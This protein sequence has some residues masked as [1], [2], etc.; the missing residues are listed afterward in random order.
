MKHRRDTN[1]DYIWSGKAQVVL[2]AFLVLTALLLAGCS[3][4]PAD[5][6]LD[7]GPV[8]RDVDTTPE[9]GAISGVV[10]SE[11]ITPVPGA[12]VTIAGSGLEATTDA[13]GTFV[14]EAL[15]PTLY[16]LDVRA[17]GYLPIQ[18]TA[19]VKVGEVAKPK[20]VLPADLA[21][22]PYTETYTHSG[23][24]QFNGAA[25]GTIVNIVLDE[26]GDNPLCDCTLEFAT[27]PGLET[28]VVEA[29]WEDSVTYPTGPVD[30][31][32]EVY[33]AELDDGTSDIQGGFLTSPILEHYPIE[34][35]GEDE[36]NNDWTVRLSGSG[37][38]VQVDQSYEL[39]TT[40]FYV[41]DAP[42]GWSFVAGD[43]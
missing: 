19:D 22:K 15:E 39:F 38:F 10:V 1:K 12:V 16:V 23:F 37:Y 33:P 42:P 6:P 14:F 17:D 7:D 27:G 30:L 25:S 40:A 18:S 5:V 8:T 26:F 43:A 31:Y 21:A 41:A 2:R 28:L 3:D 29:V 13:A 35:W 11:T 32:L 36:T 24:I 4:A 9:L 20:V 34:T